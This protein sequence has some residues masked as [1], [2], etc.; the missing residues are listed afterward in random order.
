MDA[1]R[2]F[3]R[4]YRPSSHGLDDMLPLQAMH[5]FVDDMVPD[6]KLLGDCGL[7]N[8]AAC[9]KASNE[10]NV[11]L[12]QTSVVA[13]FATFRGAWTTTRLTTFADF[14]GGIRGGRAQKQMI[15]SHTRPIVAMVADKQAGGDWP[16]VKLPREPMRNDSFAADLE[17]SVTQAAIGPCVIPTASRLAHVSPKALVR[18]AIASGVRAGTATKARSVGPK[19]GWVGVIFPP[20]VQACGGHA[21]PSSHWS[22]LTQIACHAQGWVA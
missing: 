7:G 14:I 12:C 5:N 20:A 6:T 3:K 9:V 18:Q 4:N 19:M 10:P 15:G 16:E 1:H 13:I 22:S 11:I 8:A 17:P 21:A 2:G